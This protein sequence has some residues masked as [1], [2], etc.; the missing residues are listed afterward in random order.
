[1][2]LLTRFVRKWCSEFR[3]ALHTWMSQTHYQALMDA[4]SAAMWTNGT[5]AAGWHAQAEFLRTPE[6]V[7]YRDALIAELDRW[8]LTTLP[9]LSEVT[10]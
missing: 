6:G 10:G 1:M 3:P 8:R 4:V 9:N 2:H 7:Q 5:H